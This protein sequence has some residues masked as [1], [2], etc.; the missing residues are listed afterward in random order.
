MDSGYWTAVVSGIGLA[1]AFVSWLRPRPRR[2]QARAL[3]IGLF[4]LPLCY[5]AF[6]LFA[7][8]LRA[9]PHEGLGVLAYGGLAWLGL[10]RP[11][12]LAAG[13]FAHVLWDLATPGLHAAY[14]PAFYGPLCL[15]FDV[16]VGVFA[17]RLSRR[18]ATFPG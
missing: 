18:L 14:V 8:E 3:A 15:G 6:A 11:W 4:I 16:A 2:H 1:L 5:V 12:V 9:L 13:W 17:W 10:R 7:G